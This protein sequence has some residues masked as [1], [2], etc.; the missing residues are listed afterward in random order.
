[1]RTRL[2][3]CLALAALGFAADAVADSDV[4][5]LPPMFVREQRSGPRWL[6][7]SVGGIEV[8]SRCDRDTTLSFVRNY[9]LRERELERLLPA[10]LQ[11][12]EA[13]PAI[14]ILYT[15][16]EEE[17]MTAQLKELMDRS[18]REQSAGNATS[19]S[20]GTQ[21]AQIVR[22]I[23]QMSLMDADSTGM[24]YTL[25]PDLPS[26]P[27]F[28]GTR[29]TF[30]DDFGSRD[31]YADISFTNERIGTLLSLRAPP[32]PEWFRIGFYILYGQIDW[33]D[34]SRIRVAPLVWVSNRESRR[35]KAGEPADFLPLREMLADPPVGDGAEAKAKRSL[36]VAEIG[37]FLRWALSSDDRRQALYRLVDAGSR[38][39][40]G[41]AAIRAAFGL[42]P[43]EI[44]RQLKHYFKDAVRT[45]LPVMRVDDID[46]PTISLAP[47]DR[48]TIDRI[49][50]DMGRKEIVYLNANASRSLQLYISQVGIGLANAYREG[51]PDARLSAVVGLYYAGTGRPDEARRPLEEAVRAGVERP[52][53]YLELAKIRFRE[54]AAHPQGPLGMLSEAQQA[55]VLVLLRQAAQYP[56][57]LTQTYSLAVDVLRRSSRPVTESE[58]RF[59]LDGIALFPERLRLVALAAQFCAE[60]G[61]AADAVRLI[62]RSLPYASAQDLARLEDLRKAFAR[63]PGLDDNSGGAGLGLQTPSR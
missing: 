11:Y 29:M 45:P 33:T 55:Q 12:R 13:T 5:Q 38:G 58:R 14:M 10:F 18:A 2:A 27:L 6:Y 59:L 9:L 35:T 53:V 44:E 40:G 54:A 34:D 19:W 20:I 25:E 4:V 32:L 1:M 48:A 46:L 31:A 15:S 51:P 17:S 3:A 41:D 24:I 23:P 28:G 49:Q 22:T 16:A 26:R 30:H 62:D 56:P 21:S 52:S 61:L 42:D 7:A 37:L 57:A 8:L 47:A 43:A 60:R 39:Q 63:A 36:R 50:G